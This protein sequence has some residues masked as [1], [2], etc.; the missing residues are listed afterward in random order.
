MLLLNARCLWPVHAAASVCPMLL[1]T[2]LHASKQIDP[3][4]LSGACWYNSKAVSA[5]VPLTRRHTTLRSSVCHCISRVTDMATQP[6]SDCSLCCLAAFSAIGPKAHNFKVLVRHC[7]GR[8]MDLDVPSKTCFKP[9]TD[10]LLCCFAAISAIEPKAHNFKVL[11]CHCISRVIENSNPELTACSAV[12]QLSVPL[13]Q[14]R[15]TSRC[16]YVTALAESWTPS[17]EF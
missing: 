2:F 14:R 11:V 6:R 4:A 5:V 16:W 8:V 17:Q 10:C 12:L 3:G 9:R 1:L 13:T 15:T 7:I